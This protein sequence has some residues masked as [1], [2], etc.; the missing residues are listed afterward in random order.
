MEDKN[1][2]EEI[3]TIYRA[4][5]DNATDGIL[6]ADIETKKCCIGNKMICQ[7]LG[8]SLEEIKNIRIM[9]LHPKEALPY[10]M[11]Q[12]EKQSRKE[13]ITARDLPVKRKDGSIFYADIN[14]VVIPLNG[15]S[16]IAGTF[17]DTTE[18]RKAELAL[19]ESEERF[20]TLADNIPQLC[21]IVDSEGLAS[22]FNKR[23]YD[24]TGTTPEQMKGW[25]WQSVH[26]P[27][28]LPQVLEQWRGSTATGKAF[29]MVLPLR[30]S[31]GVFR[32]FLTRVMPVFNHEGKVVRWFGSNTDI[33]EQIKAEEELRKLT[34]DLK[35]SNADLQQFAYAASHDLQEPLRSVAGFTR[36]LEK[37][38][39][40]KLDKKADEFINNIIDDVKR[41]QIMIKD[42][43]EYSRIDTRGEIF[44]VT[45]CSVALGGAIYNLRSAVEKSGLQL[46]YD[47][48]PTLI[49]DGS[50]LKRLFQNLISNAI[51]FRSDKIPKVH[52]S[53]RREGNHWLFSVQDNGI[54]IHPQDFS[55]IFLI[56]RRLH[57]SEEYPGSGIGLSICK[58][59]VERHGGQMWLESAPGKGSTFYFTIPDR[60]KTGLRSSRAT[61]IYSDQ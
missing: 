38:Y 36:L 28:T 21:W 39:E 47:A 20:H 56:F 23:W 7:M 22:W 51:K 54:G 60:A 31:D 4:F 30:G 24:Y 33:T 8:Y 41:M 26:D 57:T 16:Y 2:I 32:Q 49:A 42:L 59:I 46:T 45:D 34:E 11:E 48:L 12:F 40:G 27:G 44:E 13:I 1:V 53:S 19:A 15:K 35:Q 17:R 5:F 14:T 3:P 43:L 18:R 55:Q 10:V 25:G 58:R 52:I 9:D 29:D 50:Q 37:R 6:V 61:A